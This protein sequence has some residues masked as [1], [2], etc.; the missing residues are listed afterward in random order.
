MWLFNALAGF[1]VVAALPQTVSFAEPTETAAPKKPQK[2]PM[3]TPEQKA[4][5]LA[6]A[7][8]GK[9]RKGKGKKRPPTTPAP[10]QAADP[11]GPS[12]PGGSKATDATADIEEH[13]QEP[14]DASA[15]P[16][17]PALMNLSPRCAGEPELFWYYGD[18]PVNGGSGITVES[19]EA[20]CELCEKHEE[21]MKWSYGFDERAAKLWG[22]CFLKGTNAERKPRAGFVSGAAIARDGSSFD[23][24]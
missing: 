10:P 2:K 7:K 13:V 8:S 15:K 18:L 24:L 21:C 16:V 14:A 20:C 3:P 4:E 23:E 5:A 6:A 19:A 12:G 22:H 9:G 17:S 1:A 11:T